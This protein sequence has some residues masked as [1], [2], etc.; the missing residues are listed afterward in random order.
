MR[1][2]KL[3]C[4]PLGPDTVLVLLCFLFFQG[5]AIHSFS[6]PRPSTISPISHRVNLNRTYTNIVFDVGSGMYAMTSVISVPFQVY[7]DECE[8]IPNVQGEGLGRGVCLGGWQGRVADHC[9]QQSTIP[10]HH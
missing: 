1:V 10:R 9:G 8:L 6:S 5:T 3:S 7:S 4:Y 2:G